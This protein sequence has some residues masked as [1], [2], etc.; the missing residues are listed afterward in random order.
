MLG[1]EIIQNLELWIAKW[2]NYSDVTDRP[3]FTKKSEKATR[4]QFNKVRHASDD[5]PNM[6]M[7][8]EIP[9]GPMSTHYLPKW[10]SL[11]AESDLEKLHDIFTHLANTGMNKDLASTLT[12]GGTAQNNVNC[13]W[14]AQI[15]KTKSKVPMLT[16]LGY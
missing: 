15:N 8:K 10:Q 16:H 3:V 2:Q 1:G 11:H 14:K 4:E 6:E 13:R 5:P 7:H 9:P 12:L